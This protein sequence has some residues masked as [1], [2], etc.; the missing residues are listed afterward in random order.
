M[1]SMHH[2]FF[3]PSPMYHDRRIH[4]L[5]YN[6]FQSRSQEHH[7]V[8]FGFNVSFLLAKSTFENNATV[9]YIEE[10]ARGLY[11]NV[12]KMGSSMRSEKELWGSSTESKMEADCGLRVPLVCEKQVQGSRSYSKTRVFLC[13]MLTR[14]CNYRRF[15]I[16]G[17]H[18]L[19]H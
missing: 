16:D 5:P 4:P 7:H 10:K 19:I 14:L 18:V 2:S 12:V 8:H 1:V 17:Y 9:H 3:E 11:E 13:Q 6:F 15:H